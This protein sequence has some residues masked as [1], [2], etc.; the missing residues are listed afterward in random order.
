MALT[1]DAIRLKNCDTIKYNFTLFLS[2]VLFTRFSFVNLP[3]LVISSDV[4]Y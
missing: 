4:T 1:N 3:T 2:S